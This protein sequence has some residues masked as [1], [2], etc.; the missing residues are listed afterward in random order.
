MWGRSIR[1]SLFRSV[2]ILL[3]N[4]D[5][6][7]ATP[8]FFGNDRCGAGA[9]KGIKNDVVFEAEQFKHPLHKAFGEHGRMAELLHVA[10]G[11]D[12]PLGDHPRLEF[13]RRDIRIGGFSGFFKSPLQ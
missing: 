6:E 10:F 2:A 9:V 3:R 4:I 13:I 7:I 11:G 8:C 1:N 12:A 5:P